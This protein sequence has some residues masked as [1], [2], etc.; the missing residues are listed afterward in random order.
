[1]EPVPPDGSLLA[2]SEVV[3]IDRVRALVDSLAAPWGEP[4]ASAMTPREVRELSARSDPLP[5]LAARLAAKRAV[6]SLLGHRARSVALGIELSDIEPRGI[7]PRGIEPGDEVAAAGHGRQRHGGSA[8]IEWPDGVAE[9]L[10]GIEILGSP[11]T[12][13]TLTVSDSVLA[14]ADHRAGRLEGPARSR[15]PGW[16]EGRDGSGGS[17]PDWLVSLSHDGGLAAGLVALRWSRDR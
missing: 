16:T 3:V 10:G 1:M 17:R 11:G 14:G 15:W 13:P 7:E 4:V 5:G 9:L 6:L 8:Q 12:A 2:L